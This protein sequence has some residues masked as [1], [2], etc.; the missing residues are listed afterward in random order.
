[1][2]TIQRYTQATKR[3]ICK[4]VSMNQKNQT[5]VK[6]KKAFYDYEILESWEAGI[7]LRGHEVKSIREWQVNLKWSYVSSL[8]TNELY[9]KW[10][11]ITPYSVIWNKSAITPD[12]ERKIF[13]HKKII[14]K[15]L[16]KT[17][18]TWVTIVVTELY[19]KWW[20]IKARV[21]LA[22]WKKEFQKKH[23]LKEKTIQKE[24]QRSMSK[25]Y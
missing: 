5:I 7:E 23:I 24:I 8:K 1:M 12:R 11:H 10:M 15:I 4:R 14:T 22:K 21:W 9:L 6:N 16:T 13:L 2:I 20:L 17:K 25:H 19:L 18:E 3:S